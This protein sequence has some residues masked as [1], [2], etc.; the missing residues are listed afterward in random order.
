MLYHFTGTAYP[1]DADPYGAVLT[2]LG[3]DPSTT[4]ASHPGIRDDLKKMLLALVCGKARS[5]REAVNRANHRLFR[6][7][8]DVKDPIARKQRRQQCR[9]RAKRWVEA[10]LL[11]SATNPCAGHVLTAFRK[12]H[13]PIKHSFSSGRATELHF[14]DASIARY[15]LLKMM[16]ADANCIPCLPVHD[17]FIT[18]REYEATLRSA[19]AEAYQHMMRQETGRH[20]CLFAIPIK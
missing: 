13:A 10:G 2:A 15:V 1:L 8:Q 3:G 14:V 9:G 16:A 18:F 7:W 4:F 12:A 17:S 6:A 5:D 19:M 20:D 11:E